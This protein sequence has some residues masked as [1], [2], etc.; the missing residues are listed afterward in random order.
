[1][2]PSPQLLLIHD[3][4][5][6]INDYRSFFTEVGWKYQIVSD[7]QSGISEACQHDYEIIITDLDLPG[8]TGQAFLDAIRSQKPN[9]AIM[10][11]SGESHAQDGIR[12]LR[13]GAVD[14]LQKPIDPRFLKE[15]ITRIVATLREAG[16][17]SKLAQ[18]L[19]GYS[20]RYN[21]ATKDVGGVPFT[22][23]ILDEL[24]KA[25]LIDL[26]CKLKIVL[27]FQ[28]AFANSVEHGNL[29]LPS[30]W[31]DEFDS[32]GNDKFSKVKEARLNDPNYAERRIIVGCSVAGSNLSLSI[33]DEGL[34]FNAPNGG[35]IDF[36]DEVSL[37]SYG[38]GLR[39]LFGTMDS[40]VYERG[41]R[42]VTLIKKFR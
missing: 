15:T 4:S 26:N 11:V 22:P 9:Q 29:E 28:E 21:F 31:K 19:E 16:Q 40:V 34:G 20:A 18:C 35:K 25:N 32:E 38:R 17:Q 42:T 3:S 37:L 24:H 13:A 6:V 39:I 14:F 7:Y 27:A 2:D 41:G 10:V 23:P 30:T 1:M 12:A 33:A 36:T 8:M 5:K